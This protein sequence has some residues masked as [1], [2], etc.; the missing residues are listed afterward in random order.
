M[1]RSERGASPTAGCNERCDKARGPNCRTPKGLHAFL[2]LG[3]V[4]SAVKA[5]F[6]DSPA[7][8]PCQSQK[9][10]AT[11]PIRVSGGALESCFCCFS[12]RSDSGNA[13]RIITTSQAGKTDTKKHARQPM[14]GARNPPTREAKAMPMGAP[15]CIKAL[16]LPRT[17]GGKVSHT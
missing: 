4:G 13:L 8:P 16:Y 3:G 17:F 7:S 12:Q 1:A 9:F 15:V 6:R 2:R 11:R 5:R 14:A 10:V